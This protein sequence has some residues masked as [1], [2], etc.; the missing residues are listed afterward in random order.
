MNTDFQT[1]SSGSRADLEE[2]AAYQAMVDARRRPET[3]GEFVTERARALGDRIACNWFQD[4]ETL[5]FRAL[6]EEA[7]RL[8]SSL[9]RLGLRKGALIA[10]MLPNVRE[11]MIT[12]TAIGRIGAVMVPVNVAY[13]PTELGF[14][15]NDADVQFLVIDAG[16]L[17]I[18]DNLTDRPEM[19]TP[20]NVV[21]RGT[22]REGERSWAELVRDGTAPFEP[23]TPVHG[24]DLLNIQYTSGTT[25]FPKG[26]MLT[27]DYWM[28]TGHTLAI[29]RGPADRIKNVLVW[30]PFFYMDG[31]WQILSAFFMSATSHVVR[32]MSI[33]QFYGWLHEFDINSCT[34]PEPAL[35]AFPPSDRD[36]KLDLRYA[37][38]FG[39]RPESKRELEARFGCAARDAYGMTELGTA[40]TTP[41]A[42][43]ERNFRRTCGLP[44]PDRQLKIVD[45]HGVAVRQGEIGEL[46]VAGPG[47]MWG[48]YKRPAANA[49]AFSGKWFR[50]GDYFRQDEDGYYHIVGR[51][52]DMIKRS[53]ENIAAR[54]VES[55]LNG[56]AGI[57]ESAVIPVPDPKRGEEVKAYVRLDESV[58]PD[59]LTPQ[60]IIDA[61]AKHLAAFKLPRY[62]A[63]AEDF[64]RTPSRKV[65]KER[66][67]KE[68]DDLI[69]GSYDRVEGRWR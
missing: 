37:Y 1:M 41:M 34:F 68:T 63:Y 49:E 3:L 44:M 45:K 30:A 25:G 13:T 56:I 46:W 42:A 65:A 14:V 8:A 69:A 58:S 24:S 51:M 35:K 5:T 67:K 19:L 32:R 52:K 62:I 27:H 18:L 33:T 39:W 11:T 38:C 47:I 61:C 60:D 4:G 23:P 28:R 43:G 26:C 57:L 50:T 15:L 6:D 53:G 7:D 17:D 20:A 64:P 48:Y 59:T 54:E 66:L 55:V 31:M 21:V 10:V 2:M 9:S 22:A 40:T 29:T 16:F 36:G 12:W